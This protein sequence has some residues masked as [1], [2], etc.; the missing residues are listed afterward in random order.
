MKAGEAGGIETMVKVIETHIDN[1]KICKQGCM[2]IMI[3]AVSGKK[4]IMERSIRRVK[5]K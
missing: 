3:M 1:Y 4:K 5:K 2:A